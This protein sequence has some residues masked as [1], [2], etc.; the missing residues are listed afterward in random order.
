MSAPARPPK[1]SSYNNLISEATAGARSA[2]TDTA[3]L[4]DISFMSRSSSTVMRTSTPAPG[5]E[6]YQTDLCPTLASN[7][8]FRNSK[9][10][11]DN[12]EYFASGLQQPQ[13]AEP[14]TETEFRRQPKQAKYFHQPSTGGAVAVA[15]NTGP[16]MPT[17]I[18]LRDLPSKPLTKLLLRSRTPSPP[19]PPNQSGPNSLKL[20]DDLPP[21]P[22]YSTLKRLS[23]YRR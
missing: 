16:K 14:Q 11:L 4:A 7:D 2:D 22:S 19:P 6:A 23:T 17:F 13:E 8:K 18:S 9:V 20:D 12:F 5:S 3:G 21:P 10:A 1:S 15:K